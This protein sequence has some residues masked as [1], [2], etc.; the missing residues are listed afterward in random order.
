MGANSAVMSQP[1]G[2]VQQCADMSI[3]YASEYDAHLARL[4]KPNRSTNAMNR[5]SLRAVQN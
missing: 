2:C 3:V 4:T 5:S 1:I